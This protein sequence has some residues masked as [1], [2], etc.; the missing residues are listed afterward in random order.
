MLFRSQKVC[1]VC[2]SVTE[3]TVTES[4]TYL[5]LYFIPLF[6]VKR[7]VIFTCSRCG[8][9]YTVPYAEYQA[10]HA[11]SEEGK[12]HNHSTAESKSGGKTPKSTRDKAKV[13]LEGRVVNGKVENLR[14]PFSF[15]SRHLIIGLWVTFGFIV[16]I[17]VL[18]FL[19]LFVIVK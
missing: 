11:T 18:L 1:P 2:L 17:A 19:V 7:D 4:D 14:L 9:S 6:P 12:E 16:L 13:I 3:H 5:T 8:E 10:E 15:N